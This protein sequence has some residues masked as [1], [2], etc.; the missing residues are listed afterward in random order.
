MNKK[1]IGK[2]AH[3]ALEGVGYIG[4]AATICVLDDRLGH[5][6]RKDLKKLNVLKH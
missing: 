5:K 4:T 2:I 6:I 1:T 3:Y